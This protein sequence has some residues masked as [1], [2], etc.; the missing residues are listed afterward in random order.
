MEVL[1]SSFS[2][3]FLPM[4]SLEDIK[5]PPHNIDA[6]KAT[7]CGILM[8]NELM[9]VCDGLGFQS[10]D[11]YLK[12]HASIFK[13][14]KSLWVARK[15]VDVLTVSDQL[16]KD[17]L[18]DVV[19]GTDYLYELSGFLLTSSAADEYIKIVK[20]KAILRNIL[21]VSQRIIGDVYEQKE[22]FDILQNIEK[23]I[24]DLTQN[25]LSDEVH[26]IKELLDQRVEE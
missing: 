14:I 8:D 1:A 26:S 6:E 19:W 5:L 24:F 25:T 16:V 21:K 9:Y 2:L 7:L 17:G 15:T 11:F 22:T 3:C 4:V 10:E 23:R 20:E 18:L 13:A 12:E